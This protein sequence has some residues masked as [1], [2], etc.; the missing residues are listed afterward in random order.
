MCSSH[1]H[2]ITAFY[3]FFKLFVFTSHCLSGIWPLNL[4][5]RWARLIPCGMRRTQT[6]SMATRLLLSNLRAWGVCRH[7]VQQHYTHTHT[8][9]FTWFIK[10]GTS[11]HNSSKICTYAP[12]NIKISYLCGRKGNSHFYPL[13]NP[14]TSRYTLF[15]YFPFI[16]HFSLDFLSVSPP[17]SL[18][19]HL[20]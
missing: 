12:I 2:K 10:M 15:C 8:H 11:S 3:N 7:A 1:Y 17:L 14:H 5:P 20:K 4:W 19:I 9:I 13:K 18:S 16:S 6:V